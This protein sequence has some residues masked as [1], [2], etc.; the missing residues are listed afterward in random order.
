MA[1]DLSGRKIA[2]LATHGV[3]Q[4]ELTE[5]WEAVRNAGGETELVS[6]E[7]GEI[8][9][10][11]K[12]D[13]GDTFP[14]DRTVAEASA[15]DYDGLVIPGGVANPDFMR[16]DDDAVRFVREFVEAGTPVG[17]ICHAPWMLVEADVVRGKQLTS[18][19]SLQTD[20]RNAGG[21]W[22]D[23][24][25]VVD[26]GLTTSRNPDD[27]EAF[28]DK[29]VEEFAEGRHEELAAQTAAADES[30]DAGEFTASDAR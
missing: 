24:Q 8:Q 2:F 30:S 4:V 23:E 16:M 29:I 27:L 21:D 1:D 26:K 5:P 19:W 3:E 15:S 22:V 14:V 25:V 13:K 6:P 10:L 9:A 17:A 20:I 12:L 28:C 7:S 18:F 11:Q